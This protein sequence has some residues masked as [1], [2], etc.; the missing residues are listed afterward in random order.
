MLKKIIKNKY[1]CISPIRG[2][3]YKIYLKRM[4]EKVKSKYV[5][6]YVVDV[7]MLLYNTVQACGGPCPIDWPCDNCLGD[8][9]D[10]YNIG[11]SQDFEEI[12]LPILVCFWIAIVIFFIIML[13][14]YFVYKRKK[15]KNPFKDAIRKSRLRWIAFFVVSIGLVLLQY[16]DII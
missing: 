12:L 1:L 13:C 6:I 9:E 4:D 14:F 16:F 11:N 15:H 8:F 10:S 3:F 2:I 5:F 7:N